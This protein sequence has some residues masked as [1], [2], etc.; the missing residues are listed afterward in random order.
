MDFNTKFKD[1]MLVDEN[2][3]LEYFKIEVPDF[4]DLKP[5]EIMGKKI[6]QLYSNLDEETSTLMRAVRYGE[7]HLGCVQELV[8]KRGKRVRQTSDTLCIKSDGK[9]IGA[10]ELAYYDE[11]RD[12]LSQADPT[13]ASERKKEENISLSDLIGTSP[14][15]SQIKKKVAKI[16]DLQSPILI[17]GPT[18]TGKE[19]LAR[20]IHN[21]SKRK[22]K[23]FV[24]LNCS[25]L[26][27]NLLES[28]LFGVKKGSFTDALE[29]EGL[30]MMADQGTL[31]L[32]EIDSM[33][34]G[35]QGKLLKAIEDKCVRPLGGEDELYPDAR[36]IASCS[37]SLLQ[38]LQGNLLRKDLY[39]RLAVIQ[40]ELP[41]L[42]DRGQDILLI[43]RHYLRQFGALTE[44]QEVELPSQLEEIL[45]AYSWPGNVRELRNTLEGV[46][47]GAGENGI[48]VDAVLERLSSP[49]ASPVSLKANSLWEEFAD[50]GRNL[51]EYLNDLER[52]F[53]AKS[54]D[55]HPD[56]LKAAAAQLKISP[57]LLRS[58]L[59]KH[60]L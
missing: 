49:H 27:E 2:G 1:I 16:I 57:Q 50:D 9:V 59:E 53:I 29:K 55:A 14:S 5:E 21:S 17:T 39:F 36:I 11:H 19:M 38:L 40:F 56:S 6:P 60:R 15:I 26:P 48:S 24:Y 8:T 33:P 31:F 51:K 22:N 58:K 10:M 7:E 47:C 3:M 32:D 41:P 20:A 18:G 35:I 23:P 42:K 25:A 44:D 34:L 30:F 45:L 54:L 37:L 4:F 13:A 28:I 43:A 46:C 12:C 52:S